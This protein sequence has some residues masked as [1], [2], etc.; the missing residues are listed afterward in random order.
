MRAD[1]DQLT[2][3]LEMTEIVRNNLYQDF[4]KTNCQSKRFTR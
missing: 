4:S 2:L 3:S 1:Y